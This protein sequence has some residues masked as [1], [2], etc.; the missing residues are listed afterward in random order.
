M[1]KEAGLEVDNWIQINYQG[2]EKVFEKF[3]DLIAKETLAEKI[4]NEPAA[5]S[6]LKK[7]ISFGEEKIVLEISRK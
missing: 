3:G 5:T 7:E 4:E 1:R 2:A 6:L